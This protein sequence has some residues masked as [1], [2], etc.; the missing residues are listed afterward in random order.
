VIKYKP[1]KQT[2]KNKGHLVPSG[3]KEDKTKTK[4]HKDHNKNLK[5]HRE[6][7]GQA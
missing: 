7:Q 5:D 2:N 6:I 4:D 3:I 1:N